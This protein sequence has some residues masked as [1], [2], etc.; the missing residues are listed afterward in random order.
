MAGRPLRWL[1]QQRSGA[2]A[3]PFFFVPV[4]TLRARLIQPA[5]GE[6]LRGRAPVGVPACA[7]EQGAGRGAIEADDVQV[8]L[9]EDDVLAIQ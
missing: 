7:V 1:T 2:P 5:A 4:G 9:D 3:H 8:G 6:G